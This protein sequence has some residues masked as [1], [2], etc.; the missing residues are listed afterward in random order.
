LI[1]YHVWSLLILLL[2]YPVR[3]KKAQNQEAAFATIEK[4]AAAAANRLQKRSA[5]VSM[6]TM[7]EIR[8]ASL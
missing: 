2:K 5:Y 4:R 8:T 1:R 6:L 7:N 3:P